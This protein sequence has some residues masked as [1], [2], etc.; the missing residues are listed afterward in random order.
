MDL[1]Q[2]SEN[3]VIQLLKKYKDMSEGEII[4][5]ITSWWFGLDGEQLLEDAKKS[6][7]IV[8][9]SLTKHWNLAKEEDP[10]VLMLSKMKEIPAGEIVNHINSWCFGLDGEQLFEQ[11]RKSGQ[12]IQNP[13][14][15]GWKLAN[16]A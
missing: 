1:E 9:N 16:Q 5:H 10:I 6:G 15:G 3:P 14:T 4:N 12:I 11:A 7:L 8:Q 2:S 13:M